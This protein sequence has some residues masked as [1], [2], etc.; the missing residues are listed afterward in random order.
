MRSTISTLRGGAKLL[1]FPKGVL[2]A[3][4][5]FDFLLLTPIP[6]SSLF[7]GVVDHV[8][9]PFLSLQSFFPR[10]WG[11]GSGDKR[12]EREERRISSALSA[13]PLRFP[14]QLPPARRRLACKLTHDEACGQLTNHASVV[15]REGP[16]RGERP[17][18]VGASALDA[19]PPC[20][21]P[22]PTGR[23]GP[24]SALQV[25]ATSYKPARYPF[26]A[27]VNW[28]RWE[29]ELNSQGHAGQRFSSTAAG[30]FGD[31]SMKWLSP[32][33]LGACPGRRRSRAS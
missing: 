30:R 5:Q 33:S 19:C 31:P 12:W 8:G 10:L 9:P 23:A 20:S 13:L 2:S 1:L 27:R 17:F 16:H 6:L 11:G 25:V 21:H 29:R 18:Q 26:A 7:L 15:L 28:R 3:L 14:V 24:R 22:T 32:Q 4:S